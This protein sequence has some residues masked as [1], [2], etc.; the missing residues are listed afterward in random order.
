[1]Y[2]HRCVSTIYIFVRNYLSIP[3]RRGCIFGGILVQIFAPKGGVRMYN[4]NFECNPSTTSSGQMP[5]Q[6]PTHLLPP[7]PPNTQNTQIAQIAHLR[8]PSRPS[9]LPS[10]RPA[11]TSLP[12]TTIGIVSAS[13]SHPIT[14][15]PDAL[16][17]TVSVS[18]ILI[19]TIII[20]ILNTPNA[21]P[22]LTPL[23]P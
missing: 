18:Y 21:Y 9:S 3:E 16:T 15:S 20:L 1:L 5:P 13:P 17:S 4:K 6:P 11:S 19:I 8:T 7:F 14:A 22:T 2:F 23:L 10:K 12:T